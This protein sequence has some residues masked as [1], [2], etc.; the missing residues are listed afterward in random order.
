M[1][2]FQRQADNRRGFTGSAVPIFGCNIVR[3][4]KTMIRIVLVGLAAAVLVGTA[5]IPDNA[6]AYRG[7]GAR[8]GGGG[9][10]AV[11]VRGGAVASRGV[12]YRGGAYRGAAYRGAAYRGAAWRG[13]YYPY[14]GAAVGAAAVGAAAA[15]A[16]AYGYYGGYNNGCY[17]DSYGNWV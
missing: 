13:G 6:L 2:N 14:R 5:F 8:V 3:K 9:V 12:A 15:G 4:E 10:R 7:A 16:A 17:R 1:A 11:G